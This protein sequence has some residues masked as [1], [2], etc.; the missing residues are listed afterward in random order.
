MTLPRVVVRVAD[1]LVTTPVGARPLGPL[2]AP[3]APPHEYGKAL[4]A[5]LLGPLWPRVLAA[6]AGRGVELALDLPA[7]LQ[8][9]MWEAMHD[10]AHPLGANPGLLVAVTRLVPSGAG[11]P[12]EVRGAPR[13]LFASGAKLTEQV[14]LP[15]AMFLGLLRECES[16]G[17]ALARVADGLT[18][19]G[20]AR[21]C[22]A[23]EP[24]LVHLVA[25]GR[26]D[27]DGRVLVELAGAMAAPDQLVG[28]LL[29][30]GRP[31]IAVVLSV[32]HTAR[33]SPASLAASLIAAGVPIVVA[34]D[35]EIA[36]PA[37]RL[38]SKRL[39][40]AL[41]NGDGVAEAAAHGRRAALMGE[42][43][44]ADG[45]D[46][47]RPTVYTAASLPPA[48]RPVDPAP[49]RALLRMAEQLELAQQP[50]YIGRRSLFDEVDALF[51]ARRALLVAC[52]EGD[53]RRLGAT[54]LLREIGFRLLHDGHVPLLLAP[55]AHPTAPHSLRQVAA[56]V[57]QA[58]VDTCERLSLPAP[59]LETVHAAL[60]ADA[61]QSAVRRG[62]R[63][64]IAAFST[65]PDPL[66]VDDLRESLAEDLSSFARAAQALGEPF[67]PHTR[68]VVLAE[69]LHQW[70]GALGWISGRPP[71]LLDLLT[72]SGLGPPERPA[73]VIATTAESVEL[74]LF[75]A[76]RAGMAAYRF[77]PLAALPEDEA[78]LGYQW[79]LLQPW[80]EQDR[81]KKVWVA[82]PGHDR[83]MLREAFS[84]LEGRP[85]M[86]DY[87]LYLVAHALASAK[88]FLSHDDEAA[89]RA[90]AE[91]NRLAP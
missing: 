15:G 85:A 62:L 26:P 69:G 55:R 48:F 46:W 20:L 9:H 37:C 84:T 23:F 17:L 66:D 87:E 75:K 43:D 60:P 22:A 76:E 31:P 59:P 71:G 49:A 91:L 34:M 44:P 61:P 52:A 77:V 35:G 72:P 40:R 8:G 83:E 56:Q 36:E 24:D 70:D 21:R 78:T 27:E 74:G 73:P 67:G 65:S 13:V 30:G 42:R 63:K 47:A 3:G 28:A 39:V 81:Y 10:G 19:D 18:L 51:S 64:A 14:I 25:H 50:L 90:Y 88:I 80:H 2:P 68:A 79:V 54:R 16:A 45:D 1:G 5:A 11:P 57:L 33:L 4:F 29:A 38:F 12:P 82:A 41:L 89:W 86:V 58:V 6:N 32:C 7:E 53:F